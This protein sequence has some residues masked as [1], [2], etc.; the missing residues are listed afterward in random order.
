[1]DFNVD[2]SGSRG[3]LSLEGD[4]TIQKAADLKKHLTD[5]LE[6]T[7]HCIL[8][9][10][11]VTMVDLSCVQLFYSAYRTALSLNKRISLLGDCPEVF[12]RAIEEAGYSSHAWL[13]F[14]E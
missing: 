4:L 8:D 1:M 2:E 5:S 6:L 3:I 14:G 9:L 10:K 12:K 11:Q 7:E 13:C